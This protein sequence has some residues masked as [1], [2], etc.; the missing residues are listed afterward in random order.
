MEGILVATYRCNAKCHMCNTWQFPSSPQEE[1]DIKYYEQ[2][3]SMDFLNITGGEP[4]IRQDLE[5]IVRIVKPKADRICISTNGYFTERIVVLAEKYPS[6]GFRVS[7]EGLPSA[8]DE[9]RGI[10]DGFDHGLRTIL[11]LR[12][13]GIKDIGF[14]ITVSDR[15]AKDLLELYELAKGLNVEFA[16][17]VVHN[18]YYFHKD[19]NVIE[20]KEEVSE[21][22]RQLIRE[23]FKTSRPKNWFRA[24]FNHGLINKVNGGD[25]FLPCEMGSDVFLIDPFGEIYPCNVLYESMG[26]IKDGPWEKVWN[27]ARAQEVRE[28]TR[29]CDKQCWMIGSASPAIKKHKWSVLRWILKNKWSY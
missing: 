2:L 20:K 17:A 3:P 28:K 23:F 12:R 27:S 15:N 13:M 5:E 24:Y 25:R 22:F 4:F 7:L 10:K 29:N 11:Q 6:L 21:C 18:G 14:G 26:N 9:L 19:D 8:N 1:L 16:T